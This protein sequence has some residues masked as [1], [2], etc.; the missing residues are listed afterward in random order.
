MVLKETA[1]R[2]RQNIRSYDFVGRYG[3]EELFIALPGC[4][5]EQLCQRSE[6]IRMAICKEPVR[7]DKGEINIT[8]SIGAVVAPAG[9]GSVGDVMAMA[10]V[11]LV[12]AKAAG[13][14]C[15]VFCEKPW[16]EILQ[17][18]LTLHDSCAGCEIGRTDEC[19]VS[20]R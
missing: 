6:T 15:A 17:S 8:A 10:D 9:E 7:V 1:R 19:I 20:I 12:R 2:L 16:N 5:G 4:Y 14:N 11:A 13:R 18:P 3:G